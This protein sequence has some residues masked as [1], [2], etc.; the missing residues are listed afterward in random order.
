MLRNHWRNIS[1]HIHWLGSTR[2]PVHDSMTMSAP[3]TRVNVGGA[4]TSQKGLGS[5]ESNRILIGCDYHPAF[6]E[7]ASVDTE[8]GELQEQRRAH[9]RGGLGGTESTGA[10]ALQ[11]HLF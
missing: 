6:Q 11:R 4:Q 10:L 8:T 3:W 5:K 2:F 7:I 1:L 9:S